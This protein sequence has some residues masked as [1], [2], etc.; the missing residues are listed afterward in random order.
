MSMRNYFRNLWNSKSGHPMSGMGGSPND[1][2]RDEYSGG[3][4]NVEEDGDIRKP[5]VPGA[6]GAA[7]K[8]KERGWLGWF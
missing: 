8:K 7:Q 2:P 1:D 5:T 6:F 4:K 3:K